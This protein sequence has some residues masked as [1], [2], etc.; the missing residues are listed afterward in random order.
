MAAQ[1]PQVTYTTAAS[2]LAP[3]RR[4]TAQPLQWGCSPSAHCCREASKGVP[5]A[6]N[7][8]ESC[9]SGEAYYSGEAHYSGEAPNAP[10]SETLWPATE[11]Q[12]P[13]QQSPPPSQRPHLK[14]QR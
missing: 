8:H 4:P 3:G 12:P 6:F 11:P 7:A 5:A 2:W 14:V 9:N 13:L 1:D 10:A